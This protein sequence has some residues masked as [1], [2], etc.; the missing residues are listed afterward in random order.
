MLS[1]L[2]TYWDRECNNYMAANPG[3]MVMIYQFSKLLSAAFT[4]AMKR[5]NIVSGFKK[6]GVYLM[7][8]HTIAIP[9]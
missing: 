6:S 3:K 1:P 5:E 9:G 2:K 7:N 4:Q 8:K